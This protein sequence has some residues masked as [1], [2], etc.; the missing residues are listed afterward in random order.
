MQKES[1]V[2]NKSRRGFTLIELIIVIVVLGILATIAIVGYKAVIDR[3]NQSAAQTAAQAFD[4]EI[5]SV[6]SFGDTAN[7]NPNDTDPRR[8][9]NI[10]EMAKKGDIPDATTAGTALTNNQLRVLMWQGSAATVKWTRISCP[11]G[12][13][14]NV[15][16]TSTTHAATAAATGKLLNPATLGNICMQFHKAGQDVWVR[17][18]TVANTPSTIST[19]MATACPTGTFASITAATGSATYADLGGVAALTDATW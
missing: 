18:S 11:S 16:T 8:P 10:L 12:V 14:T 4:R 19:T 6:A 9:L 1:N 3:T 17:I 7:N 15:D 5:R 2:K 13:C